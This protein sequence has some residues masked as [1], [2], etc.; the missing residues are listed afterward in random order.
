MKKC[1]SVIVL[2]ASFSFTFA[3]QWE[4][5]MFTVTQET[6]GTGFSWAGPGEAVGPKGDIAGLL[7]DLGSSAAPGETPLFSLLSYAGEQSWEL[8][9]VQTVGASLYYIFK[10]PAQ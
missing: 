10:R 7:Q 3:Q 2:L 9:T 6:M 4:Y 8:V 1:L 5:A